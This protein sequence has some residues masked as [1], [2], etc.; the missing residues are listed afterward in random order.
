MPSVDEYPNPKSMLAPGIAGAT[1][2]AITNAV[3][4]NFDLS[5]PGSV[6]SSAVAS[7]R[8]P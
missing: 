2:M 8:R 5:R 3:A 6:S 7:P 1:T 4:V